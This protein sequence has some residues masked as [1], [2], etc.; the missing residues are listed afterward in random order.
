M[1]FRSYFISK[2]EK[3]AAS[4]PKDTQNKWLWDNSRFC[5]AM[6]KIVEQY[7]LLGLTVRCF[8]LIPKNITGCLAVSYLNDMG[9]P[10]ACEG[11]IP[12]M[13]TMMLAQSI[14]G[15]PSFMA[16]PIHYTGKT[17]TLAHCTIPTK[18]TLNSCLMTHF[19]SGKGASNQ[20]NLKN[21]NRPW[22][23][24]RANLWENSI[25]CEEVI[26][27]NIKVK[28]DQCCRTQVNA[29]FTTGKQLLSYLKTLSG[30]HQIMTEGTWAR[31]FKLYEELFLP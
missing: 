17:L 24:S 3:L 25:S 22:T 30:N 29:E 1:L 8:D 23:L 14:A 2:D 16:N 6:Q 20:A 7:G 13:I 28:S 19:E 12:A 18:M 21:V 11:D 15:I 5:V 27:R 10:S 26:A 9:I 31:E 4:L